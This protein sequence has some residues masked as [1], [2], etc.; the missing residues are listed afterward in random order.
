MGGFGLDWPR[1]HAE[2]SQGIGSLFLAFLSILYC[3]AVKLR[4]MAY[5]VRFF[6]KKSLPGFVVSIGNLTTGGTGKTPAVIML[7]RWAKNKGSRVAVLSRGY[8][9]QANAGVL[10]VSDGK[11]IKSG[12]RISGDEPYLLAKN[13]PGIPVVISKKRCFA[14]QFAK[15][16]FG[17]NFF[18]LDDGFQHLELKRDLNLLLIDASGS[19]FGNNRLLPWGPLREPVDQLSRAD[20][21][22]LTRYGGHNSDGSILDFLKQRFPDIPVFCADHLP[23]QVVFP[24]LN[25]IYEPGFL[26]GKSVVAFAG[27]AHPEVFKDTLIKL[28]AKLLY[29]KG[30]QDHYRFKREDIQALVK[31]KETLGAQYLLTTEKDWVKI[32]SLTP[33]CNHMAYLRIRFALISGRDDFFKII[34]TGISKKGKCK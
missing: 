22:I 17:S 11:Q 4:L 25:D 29:F 27:I 8:G 28:G 24:A 33:E 23:E 20:V 7:A 26:K 1:I 18:I 32:S 13:L 12:S 10:E 5:K 3:F 15:K 9:G 30:F 14:G 34:E 19:P 31:K 2:K 21:C 6:K 16:K